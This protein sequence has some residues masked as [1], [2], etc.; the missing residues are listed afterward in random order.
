MHAGKTAAHFHEQLFGSAAI[1]LSEHQ[2]HAGPR[3][4][5]AVLE[6]GSLYQLLCVCR[7]LEQ[8]F[9]VNLLKYGVSVSSVC[10]MLYWLL[11][12]AF[13]ST[14]TQFPCP[15]T[16]QI[17]KT[18]SATPRKGSLIPLFPFE[19]GICSLSPDRHAKNR[20]W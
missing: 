9:T 10:C 17:T 12:F 2:G 3:E 7:V 18:A 13:P 6:A 4:A 1:E 5:P 14:V 15:I 20:A 16:K 11:L 19:A 8:Y